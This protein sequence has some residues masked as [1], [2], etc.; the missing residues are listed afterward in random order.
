MNKIVSIRSENMPVTKIDG[1]ALSQKLREEIKLV[2]EKREKEGL[3]KPGLAV[4]LIGDDEASKLYVSSKE[5]ACLEVGFYSEKYLLP[6]TETEEKLL[7]LIE[8]LN[9]KET[10]DGILVQLPLPAHIDEKKIID[11]I[12]PKKDVDGFGTENLG[13]LLLKE[14]CF[15]PC[16]PKGAIALLKDAGVAFSGKNAVVIGRSNI[17]G[18]PVAQML[19]NLNAT[20]TLCHSKTENLDYYLENADIVIVAIGRANYLKPDKVK[21]GAYIIDVGINR[22]EAGKVVGDVDYPAFEASEK[23]FHLSPVPGGA[24]PMTIAMLLKNTLESIERSEV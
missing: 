12:S 16:T 22:N 19:T 14:A 18:K 21:E 7:E 10:I 9:Q 5:K 20:V 3:R 17:V 11:A 4:V 23:T 2:V 13:R 8:S 24:G 15:E 1:K 6:K